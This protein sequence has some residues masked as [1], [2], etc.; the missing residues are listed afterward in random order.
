MKLPNGFGSVCK[1]SGKRRNPWRARKTCGW[2]TT[3]DDKSVQKY[4]VIGYYPTRQEALQALANYNENPYDIK[5]ENTTFEEVYDFWSK[6]HFEIIVPSAARTWKSA[7]KYCT[8]IY[9]MRMK[10]LR[11]SHLEQT[12]KNA[13]VGE[14]TKSRMKSLFNQIFR[15]A[16]KHEI[17]DKNY[18]ELCNAV[19]SPKPLKE[20]IPFSKEELQK[21]W[22]NLSFPFADMVLIGVY[23]GWRPQE[24]ATLKIEDIDL[25]NKTMRGGLK[26]DAGRNR[27][28]PI[29]SK[30]FPLIENRYDPNNS[31]LFTDDAGQ[32]G[33]SMTYDKY[34]GRFKKIATKFG[35]NHRPHE[36]RHTFITMAKE[37][38]VNDYVL[39]LIVG[40]AIEDIT[41]KIYTHRTLE[42][43]KN[44]IEKIK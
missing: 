17:I 36:T 13:K 43:L 39:K 10:D 20:N 15:Y 9:K 38:Q 8:P 6:E 19:K 41:E 32:Q 29:H 22:D 24:L 27:I 35:F 11:V 16:M 3:D 1:L 34:R 25:E 4:I 18:A 31:Y 44:E 23:S 37:A 33:T 42:Q 28:V 26:T 14:A 21:L 30:I 5:T 2:E 7:Y 40:H 12:I